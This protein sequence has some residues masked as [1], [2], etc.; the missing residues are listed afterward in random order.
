MTRIRHKLFLIIKTTC[1]RVITATQEPL[2]LILT[3]FGF[4]QCYP[5]NSRNRRDFP[6]V[7][8]VQ[9]DFFDTVFK[10]A[11]FKLHK[12]IEKLCNPRQSNL[13]WDTVM[14]QSYLRQLIGLIQF[15]TNLTKNLIISS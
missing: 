2:I 6:T 3:R 10:K 13:N 5:K 12:R 11:P 15:W 7:R 8:P 14:G 9:V 4:K 1:S